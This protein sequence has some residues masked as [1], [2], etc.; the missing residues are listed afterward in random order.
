MQVIHYRQAAT[1]A[2]FEAI[3]R[4]NHQVF[5]SE[6]PQHAPQ[7]D[8]RLV[9]RFHETNTYFIALCDNQLAGMV[10][11]HSGPLFSVARRLPNPEIL[12]RLQFPLEVR[13]LAID[14]AYRQ[15]TVLNGLFVQ[16]LNYARQQGCSDLLISGIAQRVSMY[17]RLGFE[18]LGPAVEEAG[19]AFIPMRLPLHAPSR[20]FL[21]RSQLH[22]RHFQRIHAISL[23]PGPVQIG[24]EACAALA[25]EPF[26]HRTPAA[27][28]L[29]ESLRTRLSALVPDSA[30][31]IVPGSGTF[32]NDLVAANLR[33]LYGSRPGLVLA[34]GEFGERLLAH[35]SAAGLDFRAQVRSWAQPWDIEAVEDELRCGA[36]W[37]WCVHLETSTGMLNP[38]DQLCRLAMRRNVA[39]A[40]DCVSSLGDLA[41]PDGLTLASSVSGKALGSFTGLALLFASAAA[42]RKLVANRLPTCFDLARA[43][44]TP[45]PV[46]TLSM[47]LVQALSAALDADPPTP[48]RY[49]ERHQLGLFVRDQLRQ[50]DLRPLVDE[51][52]AAP[53]VT[54]FAVP[55]ADLITHALAAGFRLA[56]DSPYL[57]RKRWAQCVTM[58]QLCREQLQPL[59]DSLRNWKSQHDRRL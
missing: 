44:H 18:P 16:I 1:E 56:A 10:A 46:S 5:A 6:I 19:T 41:I 15:R 45:G 39:V 14:P 27:I 23:L 3:H 13:L 37:I 4:L 52:H 42:Q 40:A 17:R 28:D 43:L 47:P 21:R 38:L 49:A 59:F 34:N 53:S 33:L 29:Y 57:Q 35:A 58:G 22:A 24:P 50:L 48:A 12:C 54:T 8:G 32:A 31:A 7:P 25:R 30:C 36:A 51:A 9:D 20:R 2:E 26:N 55:S 11:V